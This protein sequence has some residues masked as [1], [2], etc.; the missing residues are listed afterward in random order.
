MHCAPR[1]SPDPPDCPGLSEL[2][3]VPPP[4]KAT[5][6]LIWKRC[7]GPSSARQHVPTQAR[8]HCSSWLAAGVRLPDSLA[9]V[10]GAG[11]AA[12]GV[13][14]LDLGWSPGRCGGPSGKTDRT[15][16]PARRCQTHAGRRRE[17]RPHQGGQESL[18]QGGWWEKGRDL[19]TPQSLQ[20]RTH[21]AQGAW[22]GG[23]GW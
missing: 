10:C 15:E 17:R 11:P 1:Q 18:G 22:R 9:G 8:P 21:V 23:G 13:V 16:H 7:R 12:R 20:P 6:P 3:G 2:A 14:L 19:H 5:A 4:T